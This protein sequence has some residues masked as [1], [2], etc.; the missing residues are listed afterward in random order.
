MKLDEAKQRLRAFAAEAAEVSPLYEHLAGR[1]AEDDEVAGL[2]VSASDEHAAALLLLAAAHRLV[3]AEPVHPLFRYYP[4]LGGSD[5]VDDE[6][7][8]LFREF[9]LERADRVR[10]LVATREAT[11]NDVGR[12]AGL[13]PAV[14]LAAK[15]AGGKVALL[16]VGCAAGLLLGLD[17]FG[18]RYQCDGG[19]QLVSG[20]AKAP[21]GLH[22]ALG[23][24]PGAVLPKLPKKITVTAKVGLDTH[25]V[26]VSDE[27]ELAWLEAC[28]WADQL[29]RIRLLRAAAAAQRKDV[30]ELVQGD[31]VD[32]LAAAAARTEGPLVVLTCR[33]LGHVGRGAEFVEALAKLA[34]DRPVWWVS[35]EPYEAALSH[36]LP[37]RPELSFSDLG[38]CVLGLTTWHD[39]EPDARALALTSRYGN[40]MTW[41]AG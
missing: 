10:E 16:E 25:P 21:V 39:G 41:L 30:P 11:T 3:Q 13:F 29:D 20:P 38:G 6:T 35:D 12:A 7:W 36:V 22:C 4:S 8:P 9:L 2:L 5:G 31:A 33:T 23:L 1:A 15:Q 27:D 17:R 28:V 14:A 34:A 19:E 40:R 32:D 18:Y 37:G 24:E 26:D